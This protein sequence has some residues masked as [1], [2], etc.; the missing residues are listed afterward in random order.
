[1]NK[2]RPVWHIKRRRVK[3]LAVS[4]KVFQKSDRNSS[5]LSFSSVVFVMLDIYSKYYYWIFRSHFQYVP[6]RVD[7]TFY[8]VNAFNE[9]NP[10]WIWQPPEASNPKDHTEINRRSGDAAQIVFVIA[11]KFEEK[12][13]S[14]YGTFLRVIALISGFCAKSI[15]R[16]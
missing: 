4:L 12:L 6:L 7:P 10:P 14:N 5:F 8:Q 1:M 13:A 16:L 2:I 15:H 3:F 11:G 9:V